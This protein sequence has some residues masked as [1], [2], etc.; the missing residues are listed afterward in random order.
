MSIYPCS[1][2]SLLQGPV[3]S[4][5][6]NYIKHKITTVQL[7]TPHPQ[8]SFLPG[9]RLCKSK[10]FPIKC[11]RETSLVFQTFRSQNYWYHQLKKL[12]FFLNFYGKQKFLHILRYSSHT[13]FN[14]EKFQHVTV[15]LNSIWNYIEYEFSPSHRS[16]QKVLQKKF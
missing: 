6:T 11:M 10:C 4:C 5:W 14:Q 15:N 9:S 3:L 13:T 7:V 8:K 1:L 12:F 2:P 16:H